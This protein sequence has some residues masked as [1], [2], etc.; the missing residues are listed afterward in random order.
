MTNYRPISLLISIS[1]LLEKVMYKWIYHFL[2]SNN[3]FFKNKYGF[4]ENRSY[5]HAIFKII[6][7]IIK[8]RELQ[9]P[10]LTVF[11]RPLKGLWHIRPYTF[12]KETTYVNYSSRSETKLTKLTY[13][14]EVYMSNAIM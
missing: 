7:H 5:T 12:T 13:P 14:I 6:S 1:K 2:G 3:L 9:M 4:R 10:T 11:F 8:N